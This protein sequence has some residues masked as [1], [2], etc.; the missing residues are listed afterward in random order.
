MILKKFIEGGKVKVITQD[1]YVSLGYY[2]N[3][4]KRRSVSKI[5]E[6]IKKTSLKS[7]VGYPVK[8][9]VEE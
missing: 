7:V 2:T 1:K 8:M 9:V 5:P 3:L 6:I 4:S